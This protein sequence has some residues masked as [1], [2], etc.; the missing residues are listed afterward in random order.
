[1]SYRIEQIRVIRTELA[2]LQ[3]RTLEV[4]MFIGVHQEVRRLA[5]TVPPM[6]AYKL[7]GGTEVAKTWEI[8]EKLE[9][10]PGKPIVS[11]V[12]G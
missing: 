2:L 6:R 10:S 3:P 4:F 1:M 5:R 8:L 12:Y 9:P 11:L 7:P